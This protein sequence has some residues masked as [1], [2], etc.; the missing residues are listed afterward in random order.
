MEVRND[1][2]MAFGS[3]VDAGVKFP[4]RF[5]NAMNPFNVFYLS[6]SDIMV[7]LP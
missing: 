4:L 5:G 3:L 2:E 6:G 7:P 1:D